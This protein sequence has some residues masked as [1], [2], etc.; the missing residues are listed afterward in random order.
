PSAP[1][2][3][4]IEALNSTS[5]LVTWQAPE[6]ENGII[7][8][9]TIRWKLAGSGN[10]ANEDQIIT[11]PGDSYEC[12]VPGLFECQTYDFFVSASTSRGEGARNTKQRKLRC[13]EAPSAPQNLT[14]LAARSDALVVQWDA[15]A[16]LN[17]VVGYYSVKISR[18]TDVVTNKNI[19]AS[20]YQT[21]FDCTVDGL[22]ASTVYNIS[23]RA[24][25]KEEGESVVMPFNT[26]PENESGGVAGIVI[27]CLV[28]VALVVGLVVVIYKRDDIRKKFLSP[29]SNF[30]QTPTGND[31]VR[32][33]LLDTVRQ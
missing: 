21:R 31:D 26:L 22:S 6:E 27:G 10:E 8:N 18:G 3:L 13:A 33:E 17:G 7:I 28:G 29:P 23:V 2:D 11:T 1:T 16:T 15:P 30:S 19:T 14:L 24:V 5:V 32:T 4:N 9:Y 20:D 12:E 25:T